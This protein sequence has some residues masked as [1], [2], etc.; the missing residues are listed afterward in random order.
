MS[1]PI[2]PLRGGPGRPWQITHEH[3]RYTKRYAKCNL[4]ENSIRGRLAKGMPH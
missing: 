3:L 1:I 2:G 4:L